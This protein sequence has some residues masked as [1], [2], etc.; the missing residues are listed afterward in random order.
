[1]ASPEPAQLALDVDLPA[2]A[3][4]PGPSH[5]APAVPQ[6]SDDRAH[7]ETRE[8]S[9]LSAAG[10]TDPGETSGPARGRRPARKGSPRAAKTV[11]KPAAQAAPRARK[12]AAAQPE[13]KAAATSRGRTRSRRS[14]AE[15]EA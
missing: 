12:T 13:K 8:P 1:V 14:K 6:G 7:V 15:D 3:A 11:R 9:P 5:L 10:T 2:E 4:L